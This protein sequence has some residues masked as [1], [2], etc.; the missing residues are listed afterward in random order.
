[1]KKLLVIGAIVSLV[2]STQ[3]ASVSWGNSSDIIDNNGVKAAVN[4]ITAYLMLVSDNSEADSAV[5]NFPL[6]SGKLQ[7]ANLDYS[8]GGSYV[9]GA[10][11]YIR[12]VNSADNTYFDTKASNGEYFTLTAVDNTGIDTFTSW[13]TYGGKDSWQQVPE[14][15]TMMLFGIG[16][17]VVGLRRRS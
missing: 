6:A 11:F 1:M 17:A 10:Q 14:P 5:N 8:Y 9:Q 7:A 2:F 15:A 12:V 16:L 13:Q 4:T 3:A